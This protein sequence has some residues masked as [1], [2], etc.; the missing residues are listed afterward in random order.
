MNYIEEELRRQAEAFAGL[1]GGGAKR[2]KD[3]AETDPG[4]EGR[5]T[6]ES[7]GDGALRARPR[8]EAEELKRGG[9]EAMAVWNQELLRRR[10][11]RLRQ[12]A[13]ILGL[14]AAE[15]EAN[16]ARGVRA[17]LSRIASERLAGREEGFAAT[18]LNLSGSG[19][20]L[21]A[22]GVSGGA[23]AFRPTG[24]DFDGGKGFEASTGTVLVV[25][26]G[27]SAGELSRTFQRDARRYD[28]G[29]P[30]Y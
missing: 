27:L 14:T 10:N 29:Y 25:D 18:A 23:R 6:A 16:P 17:N 13:G 8:R 5:E 1:L 3:A 2:E 11:S 7:R 21:G 12:M 4:R 9:A 19:T 28:G 22:R 30:L 26:G 15:M 24:G 20:L